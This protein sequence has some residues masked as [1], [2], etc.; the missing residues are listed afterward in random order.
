[1]SFAAYNWGL[2]QTAGTTHA[3]SILL[4]LCNCAN[5]DGDCWPSQSTLAKQYEMSRRTV[6][7]VLQR[8]EARGMIKRQRNRELCG[9][10]LRNSYRVL[11]NSDTLSA[12]CDNVSL[13]VPP[14]CATRDTQPCATRDAASIDRSI[15]KKTVKESD[16][17]LV[18][19]RLQ[20]SVRR[21]P[22]A[23]AQTW[24][25]DLQLTASMVEY[26]ER[27]GVD[28]E[29]EFAAWRDYCQ[30][31]QSRYCNWEAAWRMR[32][33]NFERFGNPANRRQV[34][35]TSS[36]NLFANYKIPE[37]YTFAPGIRDGMK[38]LSELETKERAAK[39]AAG[40]SGW[41]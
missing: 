31:H 1:M 41:I 2:E 4:A 18:H 23:K 5:P 34:P 30:A 21:Q 6:I 19:E 29:R 24:P 40:D 27:H 38:L 39:Q 35:A 3:K 13:P 36:D 9:R 22:A 17:S 37:Q 14:P 11:Y 32:I 28:A 15:R 20:P 26:A 16:P 12:P 7:R 10:F 25:A 33:G 8:L